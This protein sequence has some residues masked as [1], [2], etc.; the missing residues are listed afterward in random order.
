[1][2]TYWQCCV[3]HALSTEVLYEL[4]CSSSDY[5][6]ITRKVYGNFL[7]KYRGALLSYV[8]EQLHI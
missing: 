5:N 2:D 3:R 8:E 6:Y 4:E 1:M 7:S